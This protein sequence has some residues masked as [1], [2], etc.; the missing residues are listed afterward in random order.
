MFI[1]ITAHDGDHPYE[2][3]I[4]LNRL[5][6]ASTESGYLVLTYGRE[7]I[8]SYDSASITAV[9]NALQSLSPS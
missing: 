8:V 1:K 9:I 4:N 7:H 3:W 6:F 2:L 5:D